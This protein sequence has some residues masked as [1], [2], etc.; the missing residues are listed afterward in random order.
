[1]MLRHR[2]DGLRVCALGAALFSGSGTLGGCGAG[3]T[4]PATMDM[5]AVDPGP[6]NPLVAARPYEAKVPSNY[7]P[8]TP[9]PLVVLLHGYGASGVVQDIYF[10]IGEVVDRLGFLYAYPDG[11][12]NAEG[13]H[14][15]NANEVCCDFGKSGVDD[16]AYI[17]AVISDMRAHYNVDPRRIYLVGHSNGAYMS[18]RYA[19]DRAGTVAAIVAL[20]GTTPKDSTRCKP[21]EPVA[22]LQVHGD[23]D[24]AVPYNGGPAVP[25]A[26]E[27]TQVWA[28]KDGCQTTADRSAPPM[29]LESNVPGEET[30]VV[31]YPGCRPG[32]AA[33][34]W[35]IRMGSH[36]PNF[37]RPLWA[38]KV[39]DW[40][41]THPKPGSP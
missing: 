27:T 41:A 31:R 38:E 40:F 22:V 9:T 20:A 5:A 34:L 17:D 18:H 28:M 16:V 13:K 3:D 15:W 8:K 32:G 1:M 25:S 39:W 6:S 10:G 36:T 7:N 19:C 30:A 37:I 2:R 14:F 26:E 4:L 35:T 29:N 11:T 33:E 12:V 23:M 24:D 21:S